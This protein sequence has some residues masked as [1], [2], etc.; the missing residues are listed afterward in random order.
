MSIRDL[1]HQTISPLEFKKQFGNLSY[2]EK[3]PCIYQDEA[4]Y[5]FNSQYVT[6]NEVPERS[7]VYQLCFPN[8]IN[9]IGQSLNVRNRIFTHLSNILYAYK[10][11]HTN[12]FWYSQVKEALKLEGTTEQQF[13]QLQAQIKIKLC[14]THYPKCGED[15]V[16]MQVY[17]NNQ[18]KDYYNTD[19]ID[20]KTL[21]KIKV[22]R[23]GELII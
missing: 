2:F 17:L 5:I 12:T 15:F 13:S 4:P 8:G 23:K 11:N 9:Y 6:F 7:G 20:P 3:L 1:D 10:G 16:L 19:Y 22:R 18:C 14:Y 21:K